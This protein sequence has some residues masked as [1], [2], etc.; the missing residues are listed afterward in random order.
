MAQNLES[1]ASGEENSMS[2]KWLPD[3]NFIS[4][5]ERARTV[6]P[7]LAKPVLSQLSYVP[8]KKA[9]TRIPKSW[10]QA[11]PAWKLLRTTKFAFRMRILT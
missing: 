1:R 6:N 7:R 8:K 10:G 2:R 5:D 11:M 3:K 4:G 9:E